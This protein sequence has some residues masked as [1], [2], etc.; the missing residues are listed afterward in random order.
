MLRLSTPLLLLAALAATPAALAQQEVWASWSSTWTPGSGS[1]TVGNVPY[2]LTI[3]PVG[4][5]TNGGYALQG[6]T[7]S[8]NRFAN[9]AWYGPNAPALTR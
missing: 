5:S 8:G 7:A 3:N 1:G 9:T 4:D 2:T 6:M